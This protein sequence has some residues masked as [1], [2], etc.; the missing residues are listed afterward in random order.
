VVL[1]SG[2]A[3]KCLAWTF[4]KQCEHVAMIERRYI[5]GLRTNVACGAGKNVIHSGKIS[6]YFGRSEELSTQMDGCRVDL[7]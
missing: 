7:I 2:E 4:S 6:S 1:G 5:A 3:D